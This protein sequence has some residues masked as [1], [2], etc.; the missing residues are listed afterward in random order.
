MGLPN[1]LHVCYYYETFDSHYSFLQEDL[2]LY[3]LTI[4]NFAHLTWKSHKF[5]ILKEMKSGSSFNL[6]HNKWVEYV[7]YVSKSSIASLFLGVTSPLSAPM[8]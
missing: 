3:L 8:Q 5:Q 7:E 6:Y 1:S 2:T 4:L